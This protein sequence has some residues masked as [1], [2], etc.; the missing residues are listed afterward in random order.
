MEGLC[1]NFDG[2]AINDFADSGNDELTSTAQAFGN[3]WR[4]MSSCAA[5]DK[6]ALDDYQPCDAH[7]ER[8]SWAMETCSIIS[9]GP[10]FAACRN[11]TSNHAV[12]H[13]QCLFDAC[14]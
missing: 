11:V 7:P 8:N 5:I 12:F 9:T 13:Q 4:T 2:V 1:G 14:G 3:S 6:S 10:V